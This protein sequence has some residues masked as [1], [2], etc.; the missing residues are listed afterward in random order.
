MHPIPT[1]SDLRQK[2]FD[3]CPWLFKNGSTAEEK[4][5]QVEYQALLG[6][7]YGVTV[8][9][10]CY[11]SPAAAIIGFP[12]Q[13]TFKMGTNGFVAGGCYITDEVSLGNNCSLNPY[14][15]IRGKFCGGDG[16][17][18]G[19][20]ACIVGFNHGYAR[21]DV[22][23]HEQMHTSKGVVMGD[24]VWV[25]AHATIIDGVAVG[26]HAILAAGAVVTKDVPDYAIVGGNPAKI[27]RMRNMAEIAKPG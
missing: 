6:R 16:I 9:A 20:Y 14:V 25:G 1:E 7:V 2:R 13:N 15:T 24:D 27:L 11:L 21:I 19:A 4:A 17:R 8:G 5:A 22:P 10:N 26:S 18:I 23:I 12:P 3:F